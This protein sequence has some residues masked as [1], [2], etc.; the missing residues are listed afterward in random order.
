M[1]QLPAADADPGARLAALVA[2]AS[3]LRGLR[4]L[5]DEE[6]LEFGRLYRRMASELSHAR[7]SGRDAA[8]LE[9]LNSLVGRAYGL[10]YVSESAGWTGIARFFLQEL[11]RSLRRQGRLIAIAAAVFLG[12]AVLGAALTLLRPDFLELLDPQIASAIDS[13]A[14]RHRGGR[15]WLPS[16]FRPI[17]SSLIMTN[18]VQVSFLAFSTGILLGLGTIAVLAYNGLLLGA[19][20][21]GISRT[22]AAIY[23]WSFVAPHGVIE[24][25]SVIISA[26]AGLLLGLAVIE[27]GEYTRADA[28]R[29]A[30]Q[31]AAVMMLGV[32]VF[33]VVAGAVEGLFSPA[34]APPVLKLAAAALLAAGF[35]WYVLVIGRG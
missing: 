1:E 16:D 22:D 7:T 28:L 23:F 32:V 24:L 11:P 4:G 34:V 9:R 15:N 33:L 35:W 2:R 31:Q 8:E 26:A 13:L 10:L 25:P 12:A 3:R 5:S 17:A 14:A 29:L 20:A 21:A 6:L 27:P 19:L 18:N 30:G